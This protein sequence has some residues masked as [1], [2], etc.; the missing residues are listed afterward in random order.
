MR[1]N[2]NRLFR[3][4]LGIALAF[5]GVAAHAVAPMV[6]ASDHV[7]ALKFDGTVYAWGRN[8]WGELGDNTTSDSASPMQVIGLSNVKSV[9]AAG[10]ASFVV[11]Q[12]GT[13]FGRHKPLAVNIQPLSDA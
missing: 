5:G 8:S 6:S 3:F 4:A 2:S 10:E 12:D 13:V 11:Q 1:N 9:L 7:L